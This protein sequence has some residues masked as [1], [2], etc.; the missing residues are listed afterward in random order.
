MVERLVD[1][2]WGEDFLRI[3]T[4]IRHGRIEVA[5]A[6][7]AA[8]A[9]ADGLAV[10]STPSQRQ[11]GVGG[12]LHRRLAI[13]PPGAIRVLSLTEPFSGRREQRPSVVRVSSGEV[14]Q[15][16]YG[17]CCGIVGRDMPL[18]QPIEAAYL[19]R[20]QI[21]QQAQD[22]AIGV[23]I[24]GETGQYMQ[25]VEVD[26]HRAVTLVGERGEVPVQ[27][28]KTLQHARVHHLA[29]VGEQ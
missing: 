18:V 5:H 6:V 14:T 29:E 2:Q 16:P 27:R 13:E 17:V 22:H 4:D 10:L 12:L 28:G 3:K 11:H 19:L 23:G 26:A 9:V 7:R 8:L 24:A 15:H 20:R 25:D 21:L 1:P